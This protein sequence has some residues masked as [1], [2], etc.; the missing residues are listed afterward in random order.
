MIVLDSFQRTKEL[1]RHLA[2][3]LPACRPMPALLL[4]GDLGAGKTTLTRELV[5]CLPGGEQAEISSPTFTL[6]NIYLTCPQVAS[7]L[8]D[9]VSNVTDAPF[10]RP[11][12]FV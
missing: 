1:G 6:V 11:I 4:D 10:D 12:Q 2:E 3:I 9:S 5:L 7:G 8:P